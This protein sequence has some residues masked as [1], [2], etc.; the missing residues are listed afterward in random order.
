M[1]PPH[2]FPHVLRFASAHRSFVALCLLAWLMAGAA[3]A[4]IRIAD[5]RQQT[6]ELPRPAARIVS[7]QP[8]LTETVCAL[9][10]CDRLV[11]VDRHSNWPES[12]RQLPQVG[13]LADA[14]VERIVALRP[15]LVLVRPRNR[16]VER[17]ESLGIKVLALDAKTHADMRRNMEAV[18]HAIGKPGAGEALWH[19]TD[20]RLDEARARVPAAWQGRRV[21]FELHGGSAAASEASFIGETLTRLGLRNVVPGSLGAFPKLGP[22]YAVRAEPDL[23]ITNEGRGTPPI[24]ARPGWGTMA[25]VQRGR[26]CR[27]AESHF[28]VMVRPGPRINEAAQEILDCLA[29]VDRRPP[30]Q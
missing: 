22:E 5:D 20:V 18:A 24:A 16:V 12:V 9:G 26:F 4:A 25:A 8:S 21:Y 28:D 7:L 19:R 10:A 2:R 29:S 23:L 1:M 30:P 15:D 14:H 17:L 3:Q 27:I 6:V 13:S 11:G